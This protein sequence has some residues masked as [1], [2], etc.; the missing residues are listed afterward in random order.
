MTQKKDLFI[1]MNEFEKERPLFIVRCRLKPFEAALKLRLVP[2]QVHYME[3][4]LECSNQK[5]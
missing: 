1:L 5:P 4:I 3:K 2:I